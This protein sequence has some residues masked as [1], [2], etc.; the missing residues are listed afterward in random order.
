M[1]GAVRESLDWTA[2]Y[3]TR[4][5]RSV[6]KNAARFGFQ[7]KLW[8]KA[9]RP[10]KRVDKCCNKRTTNSHIYRHMIRVLEMGSTD[11]IDSWTMG[12]ME[13]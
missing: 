8:Y 1:F 10:G 6:T 5:A 13:A 3:Y 7:S 2:A 12:C 4:F 11:R 9:R